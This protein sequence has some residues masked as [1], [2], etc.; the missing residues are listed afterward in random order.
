MRLMGPE[1]GGVVAVSRTPPRLSLVGVFA[2]ALPHEMP[3]PLLRMEAKRRMVVA[4]VGVQWVY[5][6]T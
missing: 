3:L 4:K 6:G 1:E 5:S 2:A